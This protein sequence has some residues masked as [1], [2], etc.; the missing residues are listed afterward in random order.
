MVKLNL[1]VLLQDIVMPTVKYKTT[2]LA[3]LLLLR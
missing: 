3:V 1:V 2:A